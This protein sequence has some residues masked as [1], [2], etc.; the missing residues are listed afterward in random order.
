MCSKFLPIHLTQVFS[1]Q[2]HINPIQIHVYIHK[3]STH[4]RTHNTLLFHL[5][6][7][8]IFT[9]ADKLDHSCMGMNACT[10]YAHIL[11]NLASAH[12]SYKEVA[13]QII[14]LSFLDHQLCLVPAASLSSG[15]VTG[16]SHVP[17]C[18]IPITSD[19]RGTEALPASCRPAKSSVPR[20]PCLRV[21]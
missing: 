9:Q 14:F 17:D 11:Q 19:P 15:R 1:T 4:G 13:M 20:M 8:N 5:C 3:H 21:A 6:A 10:F 18:Q 12:A 16:S 2:A 7:K